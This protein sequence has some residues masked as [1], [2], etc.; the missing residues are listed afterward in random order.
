MPPPFISFY[1]AN[2]PS[3]TA[4]NIPAIA[5]A[6]AAEPWELEA[7]VGWKDAPDVAALVPLDALPGAV[8]AKD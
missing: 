2:A 5:V 8:G 6:L 4:P 3:A 7:D 1:S